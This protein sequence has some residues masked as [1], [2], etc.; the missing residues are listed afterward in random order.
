MPYDLKAPTIGF[1][2]ARFRCVAERPG[3]ALLELTDPT[4][5][6]IVTDSRQPVEF[7]NEFLHA[8]AVER[9]A[10]ATR[11]QAV[12]ILD[13]DRTAPLTVTT[14][15]P[16]AGKPRFRFGILA[17]PHG[18]TRPQPK[19]PR[20]LPHAFDLAAESLARMRRHGA[21]FAVILGDATNKG[22]DEEID[23]FRAVVD[24]APLP[25]RIMAGNNDAQLDKFVR[26]FDL[27]R[28]YYAFDHQGVHVVCL[29]TA[30]PDDLATLGEQFGWL[31]DDLA[32]H[33]AM[34]TLIFSHY[35]LF[36]PPSHRIEE[37]RVVSNADDVCRFLRTQPQVKAVFSGH[38]NIPAL[39][40]D[41]HVAHI[42]CPQVCHYDCAF[43]L[44]DVYPDALVHTLWEIDRPDLLRFSQKQ[45]R[46]PRDADYRYGP[47][48]ARNFVLPL[49]TVNR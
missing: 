3:K 42:V 24:A 46:P 2:F 25:C 27:G 41:G 35:A 23:R 34:P 15:R 5:R 10:V 20:L 17:D 6:S 14:L 9:L 47:E 31:R 11:Y 28:G 12:A 19:G 43:D 26:V 7:E 48:S 16:P 40:R 33:A 29:L 8:F 45:L 4:G 44:V 1:D 38:K 32:T 22:T 37:D 21:D 49:G 30:W 36:D 13:A 39:N 18:S